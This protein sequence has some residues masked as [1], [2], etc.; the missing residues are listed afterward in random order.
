MVGI[1]WDGAQCARAAREV[2]VVAEQAGFEFVTVPDHIVVPEVTKQELGPKWYNPIAT[3][4]YVASLTKRIKLVLSVVVL[5]YRNPL[6]TAK[7]VAT[8]DVLSRGRVIMG[9]GVG[10]YK[11]E[12]QTLNIPYETRGAVADECLGVLR[13]LFAEDAVTHHGRFFNF[14]E[15]VLDPKPVRRHVPVWVGGNTKAAA[16]RAFTLGEGWMPFQLTGAEFQEQLD[17]GRQSAAKAGRRVPFDIVGTLKQIQV[18][19]DAEPELAPGD[20]ARHSYQSA[21][22]SAGYRQE[23]A[24]GLDSVALDSVEGVCQGADQVKASG[25][26][27]CR[28]PIKFRDLPQCL[29]SIEWFGKNVIPRYG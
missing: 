17:H 26:T 7:E 28:V 25:A 23:V 6:I 5:P 8:L 14:D 12:F 11:P 22:G 29:E 24:R 16:R 18:V 13:R 10:H 3:L 20:A 15:M 1:H 19:K 21:R 4:A 27:Y 2:A 9:V